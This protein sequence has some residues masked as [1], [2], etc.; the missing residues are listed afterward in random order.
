MSEQKSS[1]MADLDRWTLEQIIAPLAKAV[2]R[3][4]ESFEEDGEPAYDPHAEEAVTRTEDAIRK[5]VREKVLESYRNGQAAGPRK[6]FK[7]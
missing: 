5:A 4:F 2:R 6:A 7:R 1:F 3:H